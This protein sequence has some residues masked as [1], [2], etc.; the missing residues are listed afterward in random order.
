VAKISP[1]ILPEFE[2][3]TGNPA[4]DILEKIGKPFGL[5]VSFLPPESWR[6]EKER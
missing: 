6:I 2:K 1:R 3:G 4:I 5:T